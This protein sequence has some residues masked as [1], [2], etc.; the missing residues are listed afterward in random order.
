VNILLYGRKRWFLRPP[1][2]AI[3]SRKAIL[4][5]FKEQYPHDKQLPHTV[6]YE[7]VQQPGELLFV[8]DGWSHGILNIETSIGTALEITAAGSHAPC[9]LQHRSNCAL[10]FDFKF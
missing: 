9:D 3:Y 2:H 7:C 6:L 4:P 8:P 5:W 10:G 1:K